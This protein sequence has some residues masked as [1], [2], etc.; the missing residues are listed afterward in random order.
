[1]LK[2]NIQINDKK[3]LVNENELLRLKITTLTG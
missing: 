3:D 1:M 2:I